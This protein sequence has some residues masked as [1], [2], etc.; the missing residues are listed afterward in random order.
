MTATD[1]RDAS[2]D[3]VSVI[4]GWASGILAGGLA[5]WLTGLI[6]GFPAARAAVSLLVGAVAGMIS[7]GIAMDVVYAARAS[8]LDRKA[9]EKMVSEK[10]GKGGK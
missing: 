7:Y 3:R 9:T 8:R 4:S 1:L 2:D 6:L 5:A 10:E